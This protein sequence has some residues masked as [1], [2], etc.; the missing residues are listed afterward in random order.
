MFYLLIIVLAI[1]GISLP[2]E[3]VQFTEPIAPAPCV[4]QPSP[5]GF[6]C[7]IREHKLPL[8][9]VLT[10]LYKQNRLCKH[11]FYQVTDMSL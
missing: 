7:A 6:F 3:V 4:N 5:S 11:A 2:S 1:A 8:V 10:A 9:C